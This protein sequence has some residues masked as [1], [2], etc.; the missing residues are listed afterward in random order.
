MSGQGIDIQK[1]LRRASKV[2]RFDS[3][4]LMYR[5]IAIA[6]AHGFAAVR[7]CKVH[8][9]ALSHGDEVTHLIQPV[10]GEPSFAAAP[11]DAKAVGGLLV[12]TAKLMSAFMRIDPQ[13]HGKG[14]LAEQLRIQNDEAWVCGAI[15]VETVIENGRTRPALNL[16]AVDFELSDRHQLRRSVRVAN[17]FFSGRAI[18]RNPARAKTTT[19]MQSRGTSVENFMQ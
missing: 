8:V 11:L 19:S 16:V 14:Q 13:T 2:R 12:G 3:A 9:V 10:L 7:S 5:W 6:A 17:I 4:R 18:V 1:Y 15:V